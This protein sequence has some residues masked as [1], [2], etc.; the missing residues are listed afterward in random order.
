MSLYGFCPDCGQKLQLYYVLEGYWCGVLGSALPIYILILSPNSGS[1]FLPIAVL[2]P[3]VTF[4]VL[5]LFIRHLGKKFYR[6]KVEFEKWRFLKEL[7]GAIVGFTSIFLW[8]YLA[9]QF[10]GSE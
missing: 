9:I 5:Y 7:A 10:M 1:L 8:F 3:L 2:G 4:A 6:S